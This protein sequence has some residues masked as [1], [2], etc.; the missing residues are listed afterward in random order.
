MK[1]FGKLLD[2]TKL[3]FFNIKILINLK[4]V[5]DLI[6]YVNNINPIEVMY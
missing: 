4:M 3:V 5:I 6:I 2:T 1:A